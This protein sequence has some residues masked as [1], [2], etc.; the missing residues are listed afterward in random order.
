MRSFDYHRPAGLYGAL[1]LLEE[2]HE[3]AKVMAGGTTL[4]LLLKQRLLAPAILVD[5][6]GIRELDYITAA[7]EL[8]I[9]ALA[10]HRAVEQSPV[11]REHFPV[12]A[13]TAARVANR[14]VRNKGTLVGNLC[15]AEPASDPGTVLLAHDA[16]VKLV[17]PGGER[18]VPLDRFFISYYETDI[19]PDEIVTEVQ[20]PVLPAGTTGVYYKFTTRSVAD[21]PAVGIAVLI[22]FDQASGGVRDV[23][24]AL[25]NCGPRPLRCPEAEA[26]LR[27][28]IIDERLAIEAGR[29]AASE[30]QPFDDVRASAE[31]RRH[32]VGVLVKRAVLELADGRR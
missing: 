11:V 22:Q 23:R 25:G 2:Y 10:T 17:G 27:G 28:N 19:R 8:R 6:K 14:Q 20:V 16:R 30:A 31:Y 5:I 12:L 21:K 24:I 7:G 32:I 18:V 29:I 4:L 3:R 9:G 1:Q 13:S 15:Q 26:R